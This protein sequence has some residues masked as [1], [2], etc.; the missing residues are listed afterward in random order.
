MPL[1]D[2][3]LRKGG[4]LSMDAEAAVLD[5]SSPLIALPKAL[6][7]VLVLATQ[8]AKRAMEEQD[9]EGNEDGM[10]RVECAATSRLP[11]LVLGMLLVDDEDEDEDEV[12]EGRKEEF[13]VTPEQYVL[14][15]EGECLLLV[16][17]MEE[18][19]EDEHADVRLGWAAIRGRE[20]VFDWEG[21]RIGFG[22]VK[23]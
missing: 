1:L 10:L 4:M 20:V 14:E 17:Q 9:H 16:R 21:G 15:K 19:G 8:P 22:E 13:L 12:D 23:E 2:A 18:K 3:G 5:L 7:D 6:W 11:D